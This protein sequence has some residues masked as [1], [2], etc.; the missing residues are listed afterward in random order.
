MYCVKCG[1]KL[2][3]GTA[4]CP[5]CRTPVWNPEDLSREKSY[6]DELPR[7]HREA[8]LPGAVALTVLSALA[9]LIVLTVCF[10]LSMV[11]LKVLGLNGEKSKKALST[12]LRVFQ[13]ISGQ[14]LALT[15]EN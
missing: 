2:Q 11:C 7:Q 6:P 4:C 5:L 9:V 1:V 10:K 12:A 13:Q 3:E 14:R 8:D 15:S